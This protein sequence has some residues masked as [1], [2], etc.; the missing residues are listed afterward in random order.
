MKCG[1]V[2]SAVFAAC[3][4]NSGV[5]FGQ[6]EPQSLVDLFIFSEAGSPSTHTESLVN[7]ALMDK[8]EISAVLR[9][10]PGV[11]LTRMGGHGVEPVIRGQGQGRINIQRDGAFL[12]GGCPNRMDPSTSYIS[13]SLF[14]E[15]T[16]TRGVTSLSNGAGGSAGTVAVSR[17]AP[18]LSNAGDVEGKAH[19][20][21]E[22]NGDRITL[23]ADAAVAPTE[24]TYLR[25]GATRSRAHSYQDG[26]GETVRSAFEQQSFFV[27]GGMTGP[28]GSASSLSFD[29]SDG[30]DIE[31][32]GAEMDSPDSDS[33]GGNWNSEIVLVP[34]FLALETELYSNRVQHIMD[35]FSLRT[36]AMGKMPMIAE[37]RS[38]TRG[39]KLALNISDG[40][41]KHS[42]G[43]DVRAHNQYAERYMDMGSERKLQSVLWPDVTQ[44]TLGSFFESS[45]SIQ[46]DLSVTL[47]VRYDRTRAESDWATRMG[48]GMTPSDLYRLYYDAS[49]LSPNDDGISALFSVRKDLTEQ[50]AGEV[51]ISRSVRSPDITE[52]FIAGNAMGMD[53]SG[54]WIGNPLLSP[55][56]H[57]TLSPGLTW[58]SDSSRAAFTPFYDWVEDYVARDRARGQEGILQS[59]LATIYR[60]IRAEFYGA[61]V[62]FDHELTPSLAV[63]TW[64]AY[65]NATD[66]TDGRALAQIPPLNGGASLVL[67]R[68]KWSIEPKLHF[69]A[70]QTRVDSDRTTGSGLDAGETSGYLTSDIVVNYA[71]HQNL[72]LAMS[73][74]NIFD[75]EYANHL[76]RGSVFDTDAQRVN[77]PGRSLIV[78]LTAQF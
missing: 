44:T 22:S 38:S 31:F 36:L 72:N 27:S 63:R 37:S 40:P 48:M 26:R 33:Y 20:E 10:S 47:G 29:L 68:E 23:G 69:A 65:V 42:F 19:T 66:K 16:V 28:S 15:V 17:K 56:I 71:L 32:A 57:T 13:P 51:L 45:A 53:L 18:A 54:R 7:A 43:F 67:S 14:D 6:T 74:N 60:N 46:D 12:Y 34:D 25:A 30:D 4:L 49:D 58:K 2:G 61:E 55:E 9:E 78:Q 73:L 24:S 62:E 59:D 3:V 1:W 77:E 35:N 11:S 64:A 50:L 70:T 5:A 75:Q 8:P 52:R 41:L 21:Y 76:N 39:G